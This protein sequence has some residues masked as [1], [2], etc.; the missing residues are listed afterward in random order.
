MSC[1]VFFCGSCYSAISFFSMNYVD[2]RRNNIQYTDCCNVDQRRYFLS[3]LRENCYGILHVSS[4][5]CSY[6]YCNLSDIFS[7]LN[8][9]SKRRR[10]AVVSGFFLGLSQSFFLLSNA[11]AFRFAGY[12]VQRKEMD[13]ADV[14]K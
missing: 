9:S 14:M 5:I 3:K 4:L 1:T 12:L 13:F 10:K 11:A 2:S 8:V 7:S 6:F